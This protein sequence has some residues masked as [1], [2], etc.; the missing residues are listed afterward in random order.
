MDGR[1]RKVHPGIDMDED[2][3]FREETASEGE[4]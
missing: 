1:M 2:T 3:D 4:R